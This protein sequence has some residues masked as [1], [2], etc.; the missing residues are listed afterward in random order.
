M[1]QIREAF[2]ALQ[3]SIFL[4]GPGGA[5]VPR[6]VIQA[7][8]ESMVHANANTHSAFATRRR[9]DALIAEARRAEA[10]PEEIV[11]GPN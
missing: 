4:D 2:P 10:A 6:S 9:V 7:M 11:F 3:T 8:V 1:G 5:P